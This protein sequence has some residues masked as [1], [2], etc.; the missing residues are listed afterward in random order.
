[1]RNAGRWSIRLL[2]N[3]RSVFMPQGYPKFLFFRYAGVRNVGF[4]AFRVFSDCVNLCQS[5]DGSANGLKGEKDTE[6]A[7]AQ[8]SAEESSVSS[9]GFC[10]FCVFSTC[11]NLRQ[12]VDGSANGPKGEKDT[13]EAEAQRS[14]EES[15]ASSVGFCAFCVFSI[16]V[17]MCQSVDFL[18][19]RNLCFFLDRPN[20]YKI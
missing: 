18:N 20:G 8:R 19:L 1:V 10:A 14:A 2:S 17:N 12:S 4:C 9:V 15:S 11:V 13:E 3:R 16:C 6:G 5:V 7:E